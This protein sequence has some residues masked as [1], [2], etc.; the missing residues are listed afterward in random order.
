MDKQIEVTIT[1]QGLPDA[2]NCHK[3]AVYLASEIEL[4]VAQAIARTCDD[5]VH[6]KEW[7]VHVPEF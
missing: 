7:S 5:G 4:A 2:P 3:L 6:G 1:L